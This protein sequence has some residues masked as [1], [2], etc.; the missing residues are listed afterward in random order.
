MGFQKQKAN[1]IL[2]LLPFMITILNGFIVLFLFNNND[3]HRNND[4]NHFLFVNAG[5][6][7]QP[8]VLFDKNIN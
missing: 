8:S 5:Q 1:D 4:T 3:N 6:H 7:Q 2:I